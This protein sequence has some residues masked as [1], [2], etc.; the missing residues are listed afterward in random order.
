MWRRRDG[1]PV[2][3][4]IVWQ[5][6]RTADFCSGLKEQGLEE[7]F[8]TKT[9]LVLDPYFSGTKVRWILD[10][11][12]GARAQGEAGELAFGTID[13]FLVSR[14]SGGQAHVTD[15][16]NASRTL[17][18]DLQTLAWDHD[19]LG[20]LDV[21]ASMLPEI[22][23]SSEVYGTT[24]GLDVLPDGVPIAGMA[25]DQQAALFGQ[26]CFDTG[27]AKCTYLSLIHI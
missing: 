7:L 21:P 13:S 12:E 20:H 4:A 5:C 22:R 23:S 10:N 15:V 25:G 17:L 24:R 19:L 26:V 18:M 14:L 11:V 3:N 6:R 8:R 27:E 9:G 2:H 16:S 1:R